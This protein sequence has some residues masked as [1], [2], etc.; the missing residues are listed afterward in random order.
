MA[1]NTQLKEPGRVE[2]NQDSDAKEAKKCK[3]EDYLNKR[4]SEIDIDRDKN[5]KKH[6][7]NNLNNLNSSI[8][9]TLNV[10]FQAFLQSL[11]I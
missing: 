10:Y 1:I 11:T 3:T 8:R 7:G 4:G 2:I 6:L 5:K 9:T